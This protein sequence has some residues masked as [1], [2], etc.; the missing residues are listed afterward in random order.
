MSKKGKNQKPAASAKEK[1]VSVKTLIQKK[2]D[3]WKPETLFKAAADEAYEK[4]FSAPPFFA[5]PDSAESK[6]VREVLF[7]KFD[8]DFAAVAK[9][10]RKV[11]PTEVL[12]RKKFDAWK[13][14]TLFKAAADEA[15]EK[16]FS[17]PPFFAD[18]D[19]AE[20]KKA[21][22]VLF[23]KFDFDFAAVA[24]PPR[25][26]IPTEVLL[27]KKF[28]AWKPET[29]FKAAADEA[30][31]KG[32]SAPPFFADPDSAESKKAHEVLFRKFDFDFAELAKQAAEK[33][34]AE[35][36]AA[37]KAAAEKAA[38]EKAAAEKAAAEKAAAEKAAAEKAA[39]EKAAA[40]K[41][42]A[43]KAAAEKAAAEKAAA[44][45]AAAEKAA[46]EKAAAEKAA[47][48][49]AA[50]EKAAAEK[51][52]A[53]KAAA[54]KAA[55][56]KA[57]AEKAAAEKAAAEKAAAEKAAAEKAAA[58]KAAAEKAAAEKAAAEKAAA[59]KAA[60]EK[61]AAEKA[62]KKADPVYRL[63]RYCSAGL[64]VV[65]T[66]IIAAS[67]SNSSKYYLVSPSDDTVQ[68]WKGSFSPLGKELVASLYGMK[69]SEPVK[70]VY[71]REDAFT[72][73]YAYFSDMA[74]SLLAES[75]PEIKEV[76]SLLSRALPFAD[77][78]AERNAVESRLSRVSLMTWLYMADV[79][80]TRGAASDL[81]DALKAL[82]E[83]SRLKL[84]GYQA[85]LVEQKIAM[86]NGLLEGAKEEAQSQVSEEETV[87]ADESAAPEEAA[88]EET[89]AAKPEA[90]ADSEPVTT[91]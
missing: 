26:V 90:P 30:Y 41:A 9:P 24:K 6:K 25:K 2:F 33:A 80:V 21:R 84:E 27:R 28:D 86:I 78:D 58:E 57:A 51:A 11:I 18:P 79:A 12:L 8:F 35:K 44:E 31:E 32:F 69:L 3:A 61:A 54:E 52:A 15:Y 85:Q 37:E 23:R 88:P 40:E 56:E 72:V 17:A 47:A 55:A 83:A 67:Y 48:E 66:L 50:A 65:F 59:E 19:S 81:E 91:L 36:A 62:A 38:A 39:A 49:K 70:E 13:P 64:A 76:R 4:G 29:L 7:R 53:E 45:K 87:T 1:P 42:A 74:D 82:E 16:G 22:E 73:A 71:T 63:I 14:E 75:A 89:E 60:A 68:V 10:P 46:A 5:D 20:S 43:E 34:A 77:T